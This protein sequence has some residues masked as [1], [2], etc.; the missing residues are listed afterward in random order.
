MT[1][2]KTAEIEAEIEAQRD[3]LAEMLDQITG[4]LDVRTQARERA[5]VVRVRATTEDGRPRADLV[6]ALTAALG[7]LGLLLWWHRR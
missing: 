7:L 4:K 5:A 3:H 2:P 1:D 6:T